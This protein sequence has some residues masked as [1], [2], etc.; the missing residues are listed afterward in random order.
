MKRV[1][2]V[3]SVV[4]GAIFVAL[5]FFVTAETL[6]RKFFNFSFQGAD[7]LGGYA[8]AVGSSLAFAVAL[9][10]RNHIRIDLLHERGTA[11]FQALMNWLSMAL[12]AALGL[13]F[14]WVG[15]QVIEDTMLYQSTAPTPWATPLIYPQSAW[16]AGLCIFAA[17]AIFFA[18]RASYLL[19]ARRIGDLNTEFHPKGLDEELEEELSDLRR[20]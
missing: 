2:T 15:F 7:E 16:Y 3:L 12:V 18:I 1:E 14:V 10:G 5:S 17:A 6:L 8:L 19:L 4:F 20:R 13:L 11:G 9:I